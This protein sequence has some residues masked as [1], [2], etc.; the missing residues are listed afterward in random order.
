MVSPKK[1]TPKSASRW[2]KNRYP[3]WN[4][5][6]WNQGLKPAVPE[7]LN[8]DPQPPWGSAKGRALPVRRSGMASAVASELDAPEAPLLVVIQ[9]LD[10]LHRPAVQM[11]VLF[12]G[13]PFWGWFKGRRGKPPFLG[14]ACFET[15]PRGSWR[16]GQPTNRPAGRPAPVLRSQ[17][18]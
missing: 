15:Y 2:V 6:K 8:F 4:L 1:D 16:C 3:K 12:G 9:E 13:F 5:G 10:L 18:S 11:R 7:C 17:W 14:S